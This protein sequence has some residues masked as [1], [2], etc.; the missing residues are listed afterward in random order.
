MQLEHPSHEH[1]LFLYEAK[2]GDAKLSDLCQGCEKAILGSAY[3]CKEQQCSFSLHKKCAE[4]PED[5]KHPLHPQHPLFLFMNQPY[6]SGM[7]CICNVCREIR[8]KFIYHC[9]YCHFDCC[10]S[11][12]SEEERKIEHKSHKHPLDLMQR[13][14]LFH[15]DGCGT[16]GKDSSYLCTDCSFWIHRNCASLPSTIKRVDHNHPLTLSY[17]LSHEYSKSEV[18]CNICAGKVRSPYWVYR[19]AKCKYFAH[20][21]CATSETEPARK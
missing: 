19:C 3:K 8:N 11:C 6:P 21:K 2:K 10:A 15:C 7:H 1:P 16:E 18:K 9:A 12:A 5:F 4:L 20:V 13:P 14:A 17:S